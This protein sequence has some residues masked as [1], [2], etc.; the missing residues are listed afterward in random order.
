L[1]RYRQG[2]FVVLGA[3]AQLVAWLVIRPDLAGP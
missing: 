1:T 3:A 2:A